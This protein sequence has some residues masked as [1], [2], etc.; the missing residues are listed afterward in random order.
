ML[1]IVL[2]VSKLVSLKGQ[3]CPSAAK[4][5]FDHHPYMENAMKASHRAQRTSKATLN[6]MLNCFP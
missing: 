4:V 2:D 1:K 5:E 6:P 3:A